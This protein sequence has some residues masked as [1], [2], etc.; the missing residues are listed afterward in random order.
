MF[1]VNHDLILANFTSKV[2]AHQ[3]Q[4]LNGLPRS[5]DLYTLRAPS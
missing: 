1:S 3:A 4:M 2:A 5:P